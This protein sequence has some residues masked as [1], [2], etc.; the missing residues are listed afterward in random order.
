[1]RKIQLG[2]AIAAD[3]TAGGATQLGTAVDPHPE[4]LLRGGFFFGGAGSASNGPLA[5]I[6]TVPPTRSQDIFG[7]RCAR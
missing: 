7:L 2:R 3:L 1:V 5:V 4:V 6:G